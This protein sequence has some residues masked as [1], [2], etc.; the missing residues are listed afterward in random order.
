[1][2]EWVTGETI[3]AAKLNQKELYIG[4]SAPASPTDGQLWYDTNEGILKEYDATLGEWKAYSFGVILAW[5]DYQQ[6]TTTSLTVANFRFYNGA[7]RNYRKIYV[8]A[9]L[10]SSSGT[11]AANLEVYVNSETTPRLTLSSSA[12]SETVVTGSFSITDLAS[13]LVTL[14]FDLKPAGTATAYAKFLEVWGLL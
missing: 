5:N 7:I 1:M 2:S 8:V 10:W 13:G 3:T 12:T 14:R 4:A 9:T 6:S 11:V